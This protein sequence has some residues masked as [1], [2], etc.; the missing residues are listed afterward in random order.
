MLE[1]HF[2]FDYVTVGIHVTMEIL[3]NSAKEIGFAMFELDI[4][5][6]FMVSSSCVYHARRC[7][8]MCVCVG[9]RVCGWVCAL[10]C[11]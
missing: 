1:Y 9:G 7:V 5:G 11:A 2:H 6:D 8:A 3:M 4:F 10:L